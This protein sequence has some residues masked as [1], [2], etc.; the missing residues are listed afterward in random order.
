MCNTF[1]KNRFI[2]LSSIYG[3]FGNLYNC[4]LHKHLVG[5]QNKPY[6]YML[7]IKNHFNI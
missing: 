4:S 6:L 1:L 7:L 5:L 3:F 2:F